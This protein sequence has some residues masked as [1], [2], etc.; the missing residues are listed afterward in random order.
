M[1]DSYHP[2]RAY[3]PAR[4]MTEPENVRT[5]GR[6]A[7]GRLMVIGVVSALFAAAVV[8]V[9]VV[10]ANADPEPKSIVVNTAAWGGSDATPGDGVCETAT[11]HSW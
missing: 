7:R 10:V 2:A 11:N 9:P 3:S 1:A 8:V 6:L 5:S 4:A